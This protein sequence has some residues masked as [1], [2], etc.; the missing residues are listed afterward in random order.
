[1]LCQ[2]NNEVTKKDKNMLP[3]NYSRN[4]KHSLTEV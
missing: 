3:H 1:M 2:H 4:N